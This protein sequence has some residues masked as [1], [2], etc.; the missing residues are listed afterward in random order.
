[1]DLCLANTTNIWDLSYLTAKNSLVL[2]FHTFNFLKG[3]R[4]VCSKPER[5]KKQLMDYLLHGHVTPIDTCSAM[6]LVGKGDNVFA[7]I[8]KS[9]GNRAGFG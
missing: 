2:G 6:H 9:D 4:N 8:K 3:E 5:K 7:G 1:M